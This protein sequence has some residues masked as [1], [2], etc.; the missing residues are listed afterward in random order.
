MSI[1]LVAVVGSTLTLYNYSGYLSPFYFAEWATAV[2]LKVEWEYNPICYT[3]GVTR[4]TYP[5]SSGSFMDVRNELVSGRTAWVQL[6]SEDWHKLGTAG[7]INRWAKL[8]VSFE[9]SRRD[10]VGV[11][12]PL[13]LFHVCKESPCRYQGGGKSSNKRA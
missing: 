5:S 4:P 9:A 2:C 7:V 8:G 1:K 10:Q 3:M 12:G 11:E 6:G 13:E